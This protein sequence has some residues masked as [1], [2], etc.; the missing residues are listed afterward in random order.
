MKVRPKILA[1]ETRNPPLC[2]TQ[3]EAI[4]FARLK[5]GMTPEEFS[6]YE[7]FLGD[8][9]IE[10]R[11]FGLPSIDLTFHENGDQAIVRFQKEATKIGAEA[12]SKA[13]AALDMEP[14]SIDALVVATC[15]G[16]LC[17]GLTSYI[18]EAAGLRADVFA[19]DLS[20]IGCGAAIPAL[21]SGIHF[22]AEHPGARVAVLCVE[23]SSA[24]ISWGKEVDLILSNSIFGDGAA[25]VILSDD[26]FREGLEIRE[27]A[28]RLWPKYREEL[29][30]KNRDT[31]L[32]NTISPRVP[33]LAARAVN[34]L[35]E[36]L[37]PAA[38]SNGFLA[39]VHPGGR[40]VLD[41]IE[42]RVPRLQGK[43]GPS[44]EVLR[45][46]GNMSSPSI[47]FVLKEILAQGLLAP[48]HPILLFAFGAGF[49]A[50]GVSLEFKPSASKAVHPR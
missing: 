47:F 11:Y 25:C 32:M 28:S 20:G 29:R 50:F 3:T 22:L 2:L 26:P 37:A 33:I 21:R 18:A 41:E 12:L 31:R 4:E 48:G 43:L 45:R 13:L 6:W 27:F 34:E 46:Y 42:S 16:Y 36:Q 38:Q 39:G 49:S 23:I 1:V 8:K 15:T 44:R 14:H 19:L 24:A 7:R 17:P 10:T 30:F 40:K 5:P 35:L 9:G